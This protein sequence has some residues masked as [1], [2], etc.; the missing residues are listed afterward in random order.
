MTLPEKHNS[1]GQALLIVLLVMALVLTVVLSVASRSVTEI[2]ITTLEKDAL[3]AFS[4]A[5]AGVEQALLNPTVGTFTGSPD[6]SDSSV[7]FTREVANPTESDGEFRYPNDVTSG[8]T[9]TFWLVSH[10]ATGSSLTC[11]GRP[12]YGGNQVRICWGNTPATGITPA[13]E[14]LVF[15]DDTE[16]AVASPNNFSNVKVFRRAYDPTSATRNNNFNDAIAGNCSFPDVPFQYRSDIQVSDISPAC[17]NNPGC[18]I[19]AKVRMYYGSNQRIGI[20]TVG[21]AGDLPPQGFQIESTGVA[22]ESTRRVNVFQGYAES[23]SI[24]DATVF[25]LRNLQKL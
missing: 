11:S 14:V 21:G 19:M 13:I 1:Q 16:G 9:A 4:A 5:E 23:P 7:S 3:R 22:G 18:L 8:E 25:S 20:W 10:D 17:L 6:P 2:S 24:F 12:C 15:Y